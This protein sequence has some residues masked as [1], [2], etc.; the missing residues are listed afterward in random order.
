MSIYDFF[1]NEQSQAESCSS[2]LRRRRTL[3]TY[4][5]VENRILHFRGNGY[6]L[7]RDS[8]HNI[9]S[10]VFSDDVDAF[11]RS[12]Y[13]GIYHEIE[14]DLPQPLT[15]PGSSKVTDCF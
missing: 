7:I 15:I 5:W 4:K 6:A 2:E 3:G 13:H 14:N 10:L 11:R 8:E 9:R 12:V 1:H